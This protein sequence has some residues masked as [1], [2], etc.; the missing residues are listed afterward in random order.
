MEYKIK[1][2]QFNGKTCFVCGLDNQ[3][4]L[5]ASFYE[6]ETNEVIAVF[7][8][9]NEHQSYPGRVHGGV[10]SAILDETIGRAVSI[11]GGDFVFGV[12]AELSVSYKKPVPLGCELKVIGRIVSDNRR[13]FVAEGELFLPNGEVAAT[14]RG[15][16][17]K[18]S[19][20][21]IAAD[22]DGF[23]ENEWGLMPENEVPETIKI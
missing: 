18:L 13:I 14:A 10:I 2:R 17:L 22:N 8:T 12:T 9:K 19:I 11:G 5:K 23:L 4:G 6:T 16:Y 1:R 20:D 7:T 3:Y 15:T 21:T